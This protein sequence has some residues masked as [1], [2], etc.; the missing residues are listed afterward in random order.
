MLE[1]MKK[2]LASMDKAK[3]CAMR[4]KMAGVRKL[5]TRNFTHWHKKLDYALDC[6]YV[7]P[8]KEFIDKVIN[9]FNHR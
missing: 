8:S 6:D 9:Y 5:N 3:K 1:A 7:K 4:F 2:K